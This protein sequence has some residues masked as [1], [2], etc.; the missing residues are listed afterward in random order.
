M[1]RWPGFREGE[2]RRVILDAAAWGAELIVVD[3][4]G[5]TGIDRV[6]LGNVAEHIARHASCSVEIVR[7]DEERLRS[8]GSS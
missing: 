7:M 5:K 2:P 6:L 4:H 8:G 1:T 3:S